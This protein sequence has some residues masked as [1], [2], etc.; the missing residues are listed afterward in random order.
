MTPVLVIA[1][2]TFQEAARKRVLLAAVV[3]GAVFLAIYGIGLALLRD[4]MARERARNGVAEFN[5]MR[6]FLLLA[7]LFVVNFLVVIMSVLTSVDTL[8]GEITAGTVHVTASKPL[9]RRELILGKFAGFA[10][11]MTLYLALMG[12]GVMLLS[13]LLADYVCPH[14]FAGL[15]LMWLNAMLL[16]AVSLAGGAAYSTVTNGVLACGLYG[17]AFLGGW[18]EHFGAFAHSRTAVLLG[19]ASSL[20]LPSEALWR[21]AVHEMQS[22]FAAALEFSPFSSPSTP[23]GLMIGYAAVYGA[24]ALAIALRTFGRRD[25]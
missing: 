25:L 2:V 4:D 15:A 19:I 13:R 17:I 7:G 14:P 22:P 21:R 1:R 16:L 11:M 3:L 6:N 23:N 18:I 20:V 24:A 9:R 5:V 10:S 12:G 8:S